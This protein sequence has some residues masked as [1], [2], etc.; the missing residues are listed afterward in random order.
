MFCVYPIIQVC[1]EEE[2]RVKAKFNYSLLFCLFFFFFNFHLIKYNGSPL[3]ERFSWC[4]LWLD[5][6]FIIFLYVQDTQAPV[7]SLMSSMIT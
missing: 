4:Q 5:S 3:A 6:C 1:C 7:F 2:I